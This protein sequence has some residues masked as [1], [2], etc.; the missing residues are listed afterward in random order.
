MKLNHIGLNIVSENELNTF[1]KSILGFEEERCFELDL[2]LS[3]QIFGIEKPAKVFLIKKDDLLLE[4]FVNKN[5][6]K[7]GYNHLCIEVENRNGIVEQCFRNGYETIKKERS[8]KP[9]LIFVKDKSGN[10]FEL[11]EK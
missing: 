7:N 4:L 6:V 1:Y 5:I 11:K 9:D 10:I 2:H 3:N 8:G